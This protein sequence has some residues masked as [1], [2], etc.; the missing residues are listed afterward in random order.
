MSKLAGNCG[1]ISCILTVG[2]RINYRSG[3]EVN[4]DMRHTQEN[5][6]IVPNTS[7]MDRSSLPVITFTRN[8]AL[9]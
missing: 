2:R 3:F 5:D 8:G 4:R 6:F 9:M 7:E 1:R